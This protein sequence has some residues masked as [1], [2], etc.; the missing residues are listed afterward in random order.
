MMA[1]RSWRTDV[2]SGHTAYVLE[3]MLTGAGPEKLFFDVQMTVAS[4]G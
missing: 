2:V 4:K 1:S 3:G